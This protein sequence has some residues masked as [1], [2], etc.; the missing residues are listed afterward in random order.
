MVMR[1]DCLPLRQ[2]GSRRSI[3]VDKDATGL[4]GGVKKL[5]EE[6]EGALLKALGEFLHTEFSLLGVPEAAIRRGVNAVD[7]DR[8]DHLAVS[9]VAQSSFLGR[10]GL[11]DPEDG[12]ELLEER[13]D[14]PAEGGEGSHHVQRQLFGGHVG[15][16]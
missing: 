12:V 6:G 4:V 11:V 9:L 3:S 5:A 1:E 10:I 8:R 16:Q 13:F 14:L 2:E 7:N 15:D